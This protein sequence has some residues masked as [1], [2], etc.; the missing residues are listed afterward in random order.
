MEQVKLSDHYLNLYQNGTESGALL[1]YGQQLT[2]AAAPT[3]ARANAG[4]RP[5]TDR[6][7]EIG[8]IVT[9]TGRDV[10]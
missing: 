10:K 4:L 7:M 9:E 2:S 3:S 8:N 5:A 6:E 1:R